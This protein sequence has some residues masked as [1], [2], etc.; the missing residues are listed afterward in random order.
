MTIITDLRNFRK[1]VIAF[2]ALVSVAS[3]LAGCG[4]VDEPLP[5]GGYRTPT[6]APDCVVFSVETNRC[7][8]VHGTA[9]M[10]NASTPARSPP[11]SF[12]SKV[13][14]GSASV[15]Q[16]LIGCNFFPCHIFPH[17]ML[18]LGFERAQSIFS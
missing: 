17:K 11:V 2:V 18:H 6:V 15:L 7:V 9:S 5:R 4:R 8:G 16:Y 14:F 3:V 13:V 12:Q 1:A 10:P